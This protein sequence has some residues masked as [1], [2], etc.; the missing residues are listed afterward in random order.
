MSLTVDVQPAKAGHQR[1]AVGGSLDTY[2]FG[3][4]DTA[5]APVLSSDIKALVL[6]L[7]EL[8]Y[9]SS[10]GIRS[11]F[12]CR[13]A[14]SGRGGKVLVANAQPPIRKVFDVVRAVPMTE[15][16]SSMEEADAYLD[17]MQ[18]RAREE[19]Q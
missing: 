5:L 8:T 17:V 19:Q 6:D 11:I 2:T 3:E 12:K 13:K 16:F 9:I 10:A 18:Q 1:V 4:F 15:I 14:L 7:A